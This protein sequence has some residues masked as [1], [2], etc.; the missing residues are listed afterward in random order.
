MADNGGSD[1]SFRIKR[2]K[3]HVED[4][5]DVRP[6]AKK[7]KSSQSAHA[8]Q[9]TASSATQPS[10]CRALVLVD[11]YPY[12]V[13]PDD[14]CET[15]VEAYQDIAPLLD[16]IALQVGKSRAT[17]RIFDPYYCEGSMK[18]RMHALGFEN[19]INEKK[20]FYGLINTG[21]LPQ[22]D[23]LVTNPPYSADHMEKLLRFCTSEQCHRPWFLLMPNYVYTKDYYS[24][25]FPSSLGSASGNKHNP[26]HTARPTSVSPAQSSN[27]AQSPAR[28]PFYVTPAGNRRYLYTTPK[29]RR[30][31]K[32]A[33]YTSPVP[34]FW[35]CQVYE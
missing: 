3:A 1:N 16:A 29:G 15:P 12:P 31:E 26:K 24:H 5:I 13:F 21:S 17:L 32:S 18:E 6:E 9:P 2:S 19:V 33:K 20:D 11:E 14:H 7:A 34:T 22:F 35:Y 10:E 23:V 25:L 28:P 30:Q 27:S 4:C 8:P